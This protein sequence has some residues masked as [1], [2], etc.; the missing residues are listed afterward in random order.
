MFVIE[1][2]P[3][4]FVAFDF[5]TAN[6]HPN[7]ACALGI[8][9]VVEGKIV[10]EVE[11]LIRP[12]P[13]IF[14]PGNIRIHHITPDDVEHEPTWPQLWSTLLPY[15]QNKT[16]VAH[17][18][19][20]D[21]KVLAYSLRAHHLDAPLG[22]YF[23][24][25]NLTK[26]VF[27]GLKSYGLSALA[28]H[29][30]IE[31][32]HHRARSDARVC[33]L[34]CLNAFETAQ[35]RNKHNIEDLGV[36]I[37]RFQLEEYTIQAPKLELVPLTFDELNQDDHLLEKTIVFSGE[38]VHFSRD[39]AEYLAW[40]LGA[41]VNTRIDEGVDYLVVGQKN[42]QHPILTYKLKTALELREKGCLIKILSEDHFQ[43]IVK[44]TQTIY[45]AKS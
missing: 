16:W 17:N 25:W 27:R 32:H 4:H 6:R 39:E 2:P 40:Q 43:Q 7:S 38:L 21:I 15:F 3:S 12:E 34:L 1:E 10:D 9:T 24:S 35:V 19:G 36:K 22:Q 14:E 8:V 45:T 31:H 30:D 23:C 41:K 29:F 42:S 26:K 28:Q 33:A 20:F 37:R 44:N 18:A 11:F 5:E 13:L